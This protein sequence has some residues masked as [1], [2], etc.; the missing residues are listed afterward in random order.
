MTE[1]ELP[2]GL[3][4][5]AS[6]YQTRLSVFTFAGTGAFEKI[7]GR[8]P[9]RLAIRFECIGLWNPQLPLIPGPPLTVTTGIPTSSPPYEFKWRDY[10]SWVA[11]EWYGGCTG[12]TKLVV[13]EEIYVKG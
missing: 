9:A 5:T 4:Y 3:A 12:G 13:W 8:D 2:T 10:P 7:I 11:G 1:E 6:L